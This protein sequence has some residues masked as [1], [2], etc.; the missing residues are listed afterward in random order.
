MSTIT[1]PTQYLLTIPQ[2]LDIRPFAAS[3]DRTQHIADYFG[4]LG[5]EAQ[6]AY[7]R[8]KRESIRTH[9]QG[10]EE[11]D[12]LAQIEDQEDDVHDLLL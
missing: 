7:W 4:P 12:L 9:A 1:L 5:Q 3:V 11:A 6:D 10:F 8:Q 2:H